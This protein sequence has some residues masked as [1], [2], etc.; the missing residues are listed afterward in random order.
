MNR[1]LLSLIDVHALFDCLRSG[2]G[3]DLLGGGHGRLRGAIAGWNCRARAPRKEGGDGGVALR[4]SEDFRV[5]KKVPK[6]KYKR[7]QLDQILTF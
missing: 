4:D 3:A 5:E 1:V 7:D 2:G 6:K